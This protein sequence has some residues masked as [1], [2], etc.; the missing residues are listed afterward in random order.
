MLAKNCR[1][2][3]QKEIERVFKGGKGSFDKI[4]GVKAVSQEQELPRFG[5]VVSTK[6]SRQAVIRNKVKR[7]IRDVLKNHLNLIKKNQDIL[8]IALPGIKEVEYQDIE[9]SLQKHFKKL[10]LI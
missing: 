9:Q 7:R 4:I 3:K 10:K 6:V 5:I 8:I 1:L 2:T